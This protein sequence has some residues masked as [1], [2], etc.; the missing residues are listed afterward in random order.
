MDLSQFLIKNNIK[1]RRQVTSYKALA[2]DY[3]KNNNNS[4]VIY[5]K[6]NA[7]RGSKTGIYSYYNDRLS[8]NEYNKNN[9]DI[10][11]AALQKDGITVTDIK[12]L[13]K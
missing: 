4:V 2:A 5:H 1:I 3:L 6:N 12:T 8:Y 9:A 7:A 11:I 13:V 10:I